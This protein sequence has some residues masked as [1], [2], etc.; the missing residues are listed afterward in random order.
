MTKA[1]LISAIAQQAHVG[2]PQ[3]E[4][5]IETF[6]EVVKEALARGET[7]YIRGFGNFQNKKR[8]K[9]RA[10]HI[11]NNTTVE[12]EAYEYPSF[13]PSKLF[14]EKIRAELKSV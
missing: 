8:A 5:T 3:A 9:R 14:I 12:V 6:F 10:R 13:K 1:E 7:I 11:K 2:R 4:A